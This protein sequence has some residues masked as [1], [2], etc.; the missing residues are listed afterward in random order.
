APQLLGDELGA[1]TDAQH[2]DAEVV[3]RGVDAGRAIDVHRLRPT[4]EDQPRGTACGHFGR[5]DAVG[6]D[7][8]VGARL[9]N[10]TC[11]ELRVLRTEVD[12]EDRSG[13]IGV[14]VVAHL[15][16]Y[17]RLGPPVR[18]FAVP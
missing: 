11:D 7:L 8:V 18:P 16:R 3:E 6:H 1:V 9:T 12:D 2:G 13:G 14:V 5:G 17:L 10:P 4:A 15:S